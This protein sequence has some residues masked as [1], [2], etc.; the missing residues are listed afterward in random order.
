MKIQLIRH[1]TMFLELGGQK[2]L[3][4][5]MLSP[6]GTMDPAQNS[7]NNRR[8]PLVDLPNNM[9]DLD[10]LD[11]VMVSH[12]HRDHFDQVAVETLPKEIPLFCQP[13]DEEKMKTLGFLAVEPELD[14]VLWNGIQLKRTKGQHGKG[15]MR[16]KMGPVSGYILQTP[17]EPSVYIAGDSVWC[18]D[19]EATLELYKPEVIVLFSGAAQFLEGGPIT[20]TSEEIERVC[21]KL[22]DS[23]VIVAHMDAW[24]HCL[25][26]RHELNQYIDQR[27]LS[28]QVHIP[29][30][31]EWMEYL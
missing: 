10:K 15:Q 22:P 30:D 28:H 9:P 1:A 11:A 23:D 19:I 16:E 2:I 24:N 25:L 8:N 4:D 3:V 7:G 26:T 31:G 14:T 20:M 29:E 21:K 6:P 17:N 27:E 5:P 13:E 18:S 12:T